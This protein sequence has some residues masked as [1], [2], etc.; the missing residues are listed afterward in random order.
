VSFD[1]PPGLRE[2]A[3]PG[4]DQ[5]EVGSLAVRLELER[6]QRL[7]TSAHQFAEKQEQLHRSNLS[8]EHLNRQ[9]EAI[10]RSRSWGLT[11]PLRW[12]SRRLRCL[13]R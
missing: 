13:R 6:Q 7:A 12:T 11:A 5:P 10:L 4:R 2:I 9:L 3:F 8:C 1:R